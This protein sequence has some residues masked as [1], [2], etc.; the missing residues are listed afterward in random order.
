MI[1]KNFIY[2]NVAIPYTSLEG[3]NAGWYAEVLWPNIVTRNV[4]EPRQDW[5][6]STSKPTFADGKLIQINGEIFSTSKLTRGTVKNTVANLFKIQDFPDEDNELKRLEFTDDDNTTWFIMA[7]VYT[8]PEYTH[9]RGDPIITFSTQLFAPDPVIQSTILKTA[10]GDYGLLGGVT[11]PVELPVAFS[12]IN[13]VLNSFTCVNDGNFAAKAKIIISGDIKNPKI[14]NLTSGRF[15]K[16]LVDM[17]INDELIIDTENYTVKLN[18]NNVLTYR[19]EGSNWPFVNSG[20][21]YFLLIGDDFDFDN[22]NK[23]GV[24][25]QWRDTKLV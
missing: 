17:G 16:V 11:L 10:S 19:A 1:G 13:G 18:G 24:E 3:R 8:M 25:V 6:G 5:H 7:K 15:F 22:Y 20:T 12:S 14:I 2:N 21:N 4:V 23:A 9:G